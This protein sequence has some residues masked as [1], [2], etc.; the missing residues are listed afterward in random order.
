MPIR[1]TLQPYQ[2]QI[3]GI[4]TLYAISESVMC[5]N[6][7][8]PRLKDFRLCELSVELAASVI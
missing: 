8:S 3:R 7:L 1:N 2:N 4:S 6:L 5:A